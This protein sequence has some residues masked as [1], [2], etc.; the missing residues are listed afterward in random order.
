MSIDD[1]AYLKDIGITISQDSLVEDVHFLRNKITPFQLGWKT[2]MVNISDICASGAEPKYLTTALSLPKTTTKDFIEEFYNGIKTACPN[3]EI[4]GGDLTASDKIYISATAIGITSQRNISS[5]TNAQV[6]QKI[7]ISGNCGSS[8]GGLQL[9]LENK[10]SP[11]SLIK[12]HL[13]PIAQQEFSKNIATTQKKPYAMMDTSDGLMDA[14]IQIAKA[15]NVIMK[16]DFD[17]IPYAQEIKTFTNWKELV[18]YGAEDYQLIATVDT[19]PKDA[20]IIGEVEQTLQSFGVKINNDF[21][22]EASIN[23]KCFKHFK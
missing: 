13:E 23:G 21:L 15:S 10:T 11:A 3:I 5:R 8:A 2:A 17:K 20:I 19:P 14:L 16:I 7:I 1:C 9:L 6:G 22:S 12:A 4:I 18:L